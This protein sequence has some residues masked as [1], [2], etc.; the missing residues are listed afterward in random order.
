MGILLVEPAIISD[1][2]VSGLADAEDLGDGNIRFTYFTKQKSFM[3]YANVTE[4][5]IVARIVIP[6]SALFPARQLTGKRLGICCEMRHAR[7]AH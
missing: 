2:F 6:F 7:L 3:D 1:I 5:V 4:H